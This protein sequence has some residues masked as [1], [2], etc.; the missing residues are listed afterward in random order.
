MTSLGY[1]DIVTENTKRDQ[2]RARQGSGKKNPAVFDRVT[3]VGS[4]R[5]ARAEVDKTDEKVD[6]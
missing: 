3:C 1:A 4:G 2:I 5:P 6:C